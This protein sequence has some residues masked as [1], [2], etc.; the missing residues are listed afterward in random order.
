M[1][2]VWRLWPVS[3]GGSDVVMVGKLANLLFVV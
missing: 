2:S 1:T 3:V